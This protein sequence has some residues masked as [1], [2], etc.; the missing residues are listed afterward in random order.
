MKKTLTNS[1]KLKRRNL[2]TLAALIGLMV[3]FYLITV[4]RLGGL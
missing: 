3:L 1:P 2:V 4:V